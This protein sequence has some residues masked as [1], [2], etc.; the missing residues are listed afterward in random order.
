M[1]DLMTCFDYGG[2]GEKFYIYDDKAFVQERPAI[3]LKKENADEFTHVLKSFVHSFRDNALM[4]HKMSKLPFENR[5]F[6]DRFYKLTDKYSFSIFYEMPEKNE[7]I[8][9]IHD[10]KNKIVYNDGILKKLLHG[11][12][13]PGELLYNGRVIFNKDVLKKLERKEKGDVLLSIEEVYESFKDDDD[14][15]YLNEILNEYKHPCVITSAGTLRFQEQELNKEEKVMESDINAIWMNFGTK[16]SLSDVI[17]FY[18]KIGYSLSGFCEVFGSHFCEV[19]YEND[20][21][22]FKSA[23]EIREIIK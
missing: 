3:I 8:G 2:P 17:K 23:E 1:S 5:E 6:D 15:I 18:M 19:Y 9:N 11:K 13:L 12:K 16:Y 14:W 20:E 10:D 22:I 21:Y 4:L 7:V